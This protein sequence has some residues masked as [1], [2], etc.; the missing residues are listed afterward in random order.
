MTLS[1]LKRPSAD[2]LRGYTLIELM[3]AITIGFILIAA[4]LSTFIWSVRNYDQDDSTARQQEN[5][6]FALDAIADDL[7]MSGFMYDVLLSSG[8]DT[9]AVSSLL[10]S[11]DCGA[12]GEN[13]AFDTSDLLASLHAATPTEIETS[14]ILNTGQ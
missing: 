13:W 1:P 3:V 11:N 9:D 6:R 10:G 12:T 14:A 4:V 8:V 2:L 5:A 7:R